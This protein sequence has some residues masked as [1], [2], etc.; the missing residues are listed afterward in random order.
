MTWYIR[1]PVQTVRERV[2][3]ST[4]TSEEGKKPIT[5]EKLALQLR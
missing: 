3:N 4:T 1:V 2:W 5:R